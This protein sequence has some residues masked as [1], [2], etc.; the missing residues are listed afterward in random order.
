[1]L[2]ISHQMHGQVFMRRASALLTVVG[3]ILVVTMFGCRE[4]LGTELD[5]NLPPDTYITGAPAESTTAF[6]KVHLYWYGDDADGKVVGYE[7]VITDSMP[8]DEDTLTYAYT[9]R[10]DSLFAFPVEPNQQ[11]VGHRFYV[12]AID[13]MGAEDPNP[14]ITFFGVADLIAP[15]PVFGLA[16]AYDP[17]NEANFKDITSTNPIVP[18]DTI[19][20]G[21]DVEFEWSGYDADS[22][23]TEDGRL[24]VAGEVMGYEYILRGLD[25]APIRVDQ[26]DTTAVYDNLNNSVY[27]FQLRA[28]DDAGFMG[29]DPE[30]R[31]FV[32]NYDPNTYF[33]DPRGDDL[34]SRAVVTSDGWNGER[35]FYEGD[36]IPLTG[37]H[38][39][40]YSK[41]VSV[42]VR[43]ELWGIDSD[44]FLGTGLSRFQYRKGVARYERAD[45][46]PDYDPLDPQER[47]YAASI[48]LE[49]QYT[50][51]ISLYA[52]C[53]DGYG[54]QDGTAARFPLFINR[55]P[56]LLDTLDVVD[57]V[58][59][60]QYPNEFEPI[61]MDSVRSWG[62][63]IPIRL[64]AWDPDTTTYWFR[65]QWVIS[66][67]GGALYGPESDRINGIYDAWLDLPHDFSMN[68]D[69]LLIR[70]SEGL[71]N[72]SSDGGRHSDLRIPLNFV[73]N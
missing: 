22:M 29:L 46:N 4:E 39:T 61:P 72:S 56:R 36:T 59:I 45:I 3:A 7:Y 17:D 65:Y 54:Q 43:F 64:R 48:L 69:T 14:A 44:D 15:T 30:Q 10:T 62:N 37:E 19:R 40:S 60:M 52:R 2:K 70:V 5:T 57:D 12:R 21:W 8:A 24:V 25:T 49:S 41:S 58:P 73:D 23:I 16:R 63:R 9:T 35:V 32:W 26:D 47:D 28:V 51:S 31:S 18:A 33:F 53:F 27:V 34:R 55:G 42:D 71:A 66:P 11:V 6:Y 67:S 50:T 20:A 68:G 1:M 38:R 13:D